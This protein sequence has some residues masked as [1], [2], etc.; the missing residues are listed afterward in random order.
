MTT[1]RATGRRAFKH[2][3]R[4]RADQITLPPPPDQWAC[5]LDCAGVWAVRC[6]PR[7]RRC[8]QFSACPV[9]PTY[10]KL[11]TALIVPHLWRPLASDS[12][13]L[14]W[15]LPRSPLG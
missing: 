10:G 15:S 14:S 5:A 11:A 8:L 7:I 13:A 6:A 4:L 3:F 9:A 12:L 1:A 2:I